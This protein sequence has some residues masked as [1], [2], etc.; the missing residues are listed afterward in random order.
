MRVSRRERQV[1]QAREG[2]GRSNHRTIEPSN[3]RTSNHRIKPQIPN[4]KSP[5][6]FHHSMFDV[7]GSTFFLSFASLAV[8]LFAAYHPR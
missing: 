3:H 1:R 4:L 7:E 6:L 5:L 8:D 2:G